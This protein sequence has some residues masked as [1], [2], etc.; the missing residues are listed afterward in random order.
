MFTG[1]FKFFLFAVSGSLLFIQIHNRLILIL[2][3]GAFRTSLTIFVFGVLVFLFGISALIIQSR[4]LTLSAIVI[5]VSCLAIEICQRVHKNALRVKESID[6]WHWNEP[7]VSNGWFQDTSELLIVRRFFHSP[8]TWK[9]G[10][11]R[12]AHISDLHVDRH[13]SDNFIETV[14]DAL[15]SLKP[16]TVIVTGDFADEINE[17]K[18]LVS[19][20][21]N[22]SPPRGI[23]GVLGNHDF[24][25][26][27]HAV[28]KILESSGIQ[29]PSYKGLTLDINRSQKLIFHG[30]DYPYAKPWLLNNQK[31][32]KTTIALAHTPDVVFKLARAGIDMVFSGHLHGGQWR[33]PLIGSVVS[34]SIYDRLLDHGHYKIL[35][36]DLFVTSGIG[37][38]WI[39]KRVNCPAEI[40]VVDLTGS[41]DPSPSGNRTSPDFPDRQV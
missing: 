13:T 7:S 28:R 36:T 30:I 10:T 1:I 24:W 41:Q 33:L 40:L 23:F 37:K 32:D 17:L 22:L 15:A 26:N 4:S 31:L 19:L 2:K 12:I 29:F 14:F 8:S 18:R 39:P 38:V 11:F 6:T 21:K 20:F 34:P 5:I 25:I 16:D 35:Q 9:T 3:K 27:D